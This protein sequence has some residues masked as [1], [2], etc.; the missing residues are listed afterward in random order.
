VNEYQQSLLRGCVPTQW[1]FNL[2]TGGAAQHAANITMETYVQLLSNKNP[3]SP[4][5]QPFTG[6]LACHGLSKWDQSFVFLEAK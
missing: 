2:N 3:K 4:S 5:T 1:Q 6:C